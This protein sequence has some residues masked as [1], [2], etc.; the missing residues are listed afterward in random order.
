M[1]TL[2]EVTLI[3]LL[4][5]VAVL[6]LVLWRLWQVLQ[7]TRRALQVPRQ[8]QEVGRGSEIATRREIL[9]LSSVSGRGY[10]P[11]VYVFDTKE[12]CFRRVGVVDASGVLGGGDLREGEDGIRLV[13]GRLYRLVTRPQRAA[14]RP[15]RLVIGDGTTPGGASDWAVHDI[16]VGH[17]SQFVQSGVISGGM[18]GASAVDAFVQFSTVQTAMD[19]GIEVSY[20]GPNDSEPFVCS[21][22]GTSVAVY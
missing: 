10:A 12:H 3:V 16:T 9:P 19:L 7:A 13:R 15:E 8:A 14:F 6:A 17:M 2:Q 1:S 18:F 21:A 11:E 5:L 20:T 4:G 22:V